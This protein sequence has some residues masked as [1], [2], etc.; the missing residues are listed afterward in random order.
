[1]ILYTTA[2]KDYRLPNGLNP[3]QQAL[4]VHLI[5][6]KWQNIST[7]P[8]TALGQKYDAILPD[9]LPRTGISPLIYPSLAAALTAHRQKNAFRIHKHFYH[10]A[11]S[12]AANI[13]LLLPVLHNPN[14]SKILRAI[15]PDF[16]SLATDHLDQGYC[17]E[18]WGG[19]VEDGRI[20]SPHAG[21]LGDKSAMAGTDADI[22][23]A[24]HNHQGEPCLWLIE[25][26]LTEKEFSQ[27]GAFKSNGR[28]T[29]HNCT[30]G[31]SGL[32]ADKHAC[33]YHDVRKF[34]YW[35]LTDAHQAFFAKHTPY[36]SCPFRGGMNQLWRNQLL[37]LAI[38]QS[39][40][41][42]YEHVSF[43]V[44]K[45]PRNT[46]LDSTLTRYQALID[47]NPKFSVFQSDALVRAAEAQG[48]EELDTW[49]R[50]YRDL[51]ACGK[52]F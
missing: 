33:Y 49:A 4:Y 38:E 43:S 28:T 17:L 3:F 8:G 40:A 41:H 44:V 2:G 35:E 51:Y 18:F 26:K 27:C 39:P 47:N 7:E 24:Y 14:A 25:H 50:W 31:F 23:I 22:A 15:K 37:G 48:D 13:N 29:R 5:N 11:S 46:S 9:S 1:M 6:W 45:H 34:K 16:A 36:P 52:N 10:M 12:Q 20:T 42:P 32:L 21:L 30:K 19:N